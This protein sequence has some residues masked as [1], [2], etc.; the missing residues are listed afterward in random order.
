VCK[1]FHEG[2]FKAD[3]CDDYL[4]QYL[5]IVGAEHKRV[6][7]SISRFLI[8]K[9]ELAIITVPSLSGRGELHAIVVDTRYKLERIYDP[10]FGEQYVSDHLVD[11]AKGKF[12]ILLFIKSFVLWPK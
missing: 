2:Y 8:K 6:R 1:E 10:S 4:S 7:N 9:G 5:T 12:P 11:T 3:D